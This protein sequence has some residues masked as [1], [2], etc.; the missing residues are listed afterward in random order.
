MEWIEPLITVFCIVG[1]GISLYYVRKL[2]RELD[3]DE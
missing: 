3:D 2:E 1:V